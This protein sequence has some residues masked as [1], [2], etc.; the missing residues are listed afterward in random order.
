MFQLKKGLSISVGGAVRSRALR[1]FKK[2][3]RTWGYALPDVEPLV[4]DFGLGDFARTGL[5][6]Y[7]LANERR[8]G[9]CGKYL[10]VFAGQTCPRHRH[11]TKHET[12][13]LL[14]GNLSVT[15]GTKLLHLKPG[16]VLAI[17]PGIYHSFTGKGPAL[18]LELS[19]P[20]DVSDNFFAD[21]RIP[22]GGN[23]QRR[24]GGVPPRVSDAAGDKSTKR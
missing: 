23:Q 12:F 1:E 9:Y 13:F 5:I 6:E 15:Y 8:A 3:I 10:F 21:A 11:R 16:D 4:L 20:C 17:A 7:W 19:M 18:L 14:E 24:S 2:L 22:I